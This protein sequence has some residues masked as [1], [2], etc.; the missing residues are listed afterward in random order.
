[1][2]NIQ[3]LINQI[4]IGDLIKIFNI[5]VAI[6]VFLIFIIFRGLFSKIILKIF[7]WI[8]KDKRKAK[9]SKAFKVLNNFLVFLGLYCAIR[10]LK[11][12]PKQLVFV[13]TAFRIVCIIFITNFINS[14]ITKNA[15]WFKRHIN[16]TR[17][18]SV[19]GFICKIIRGVVW[20]ISGYIIIKELGYDL[21]GL[22]AG[23]GIGG[24][25]ISFAA[26]DTV[27]SLLSGAVILT[28]KPFD[29]GDYI[30]VG[31]YKG[32]VIDIT[33]RST[34]IRALDNS[35]ITIPNS[36][37]TSEYVVNWNKLKSRRLEFVL[38]LS[39]ETTSEK[40]KRIIS[41]IKL[42]LT[43][44]PDVLPDTVQVNLAEISSY[45]SDIKI[46]MYINESDYIKFLNAKERIYCDILELVEIENID[47]AYP[48]QTVYVKNGNVD[49][50]D[51]KEA[52]IEEL[53]G[54]DDEMLAM[55]MLAEE[56]N[57]KKNS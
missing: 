28:D 56:E 34:R 52:Q 7:F 20:V 17:N 16:H 9:E 18:D 4:N 15:R 3:S 26:Q 27:K 5:Q 6:A 13:N 37:I 29:I 44:N 38:N 25:V 12:N 31:N 42:V 50:F 11:P 30:E 10:I 51:I 45:S 54:D 22:V 1:M 53:I 55:K 32:N 8:T 14:G 23:F 41:K 33:F 57:K 48:T 46:F 24:V 35:V 39:M 21:T 19:N 40:I 47:L 2:E 36:T 49:K 43:N